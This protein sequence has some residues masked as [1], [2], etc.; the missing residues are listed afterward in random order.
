MDSLLQVLLHLMD[1]GFPLGSN[2][3][4]N[5]YVLSNEMEFSLHGPE[6]HPLR[7]HLLLHQVDLLLQLHYPTLLP[8]Y[9][10]HQP[11]TLLLFFLQLSSMQF[12]DLSQ[13]LL[14]FEFLLFL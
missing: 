9:P 3:L 8:L 2:A 5:D 1:G 10:L 11:P 12:P 4:S 13:V 7:L 6:L 14:Y